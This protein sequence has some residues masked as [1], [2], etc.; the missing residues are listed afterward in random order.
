[1]KVCFHLPVSTTATPFRTF[2]RHTVYG[3]PP[4]SSY[5]GTARAQ[6]QAVD[7]RPHIHPAPAQIRKVVLAPSRNEVSILIDSE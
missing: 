5:T 4:P 2:A 7:E 3:I 6:Y 1:M